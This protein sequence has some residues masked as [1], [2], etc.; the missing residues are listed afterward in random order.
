MQ[1]KVAISLL[2]EINDE[3]RFEY[4]EQLESFYMVVLRNNDLG[5]HL[6]KG[7]ILEILR[8]GVLGGVAAASRRTE[9]EIAQIVAQSG[10]STYKH[11]K[12]V[13]CRHRLYQTIRRWVIE[14]RYIK[15]EEIVKYHSSLFIYCFL[16]TVPEE[17]KSEWAPMAVFKDIIKRISL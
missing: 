3:Y 11:V 12:E 6:M 2:T 1:Y 17:Q 5:M 14:K 15:L 13:G 4:A 16:L 7:L 9:G 10:E 8:Y